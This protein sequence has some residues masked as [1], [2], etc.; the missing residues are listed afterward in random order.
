[1]RF[2]RQRGS[3]SVMVRVFIPN[4]LSTVGAGCTGLTYASTNLSIGWIRE[5]G[6]SFT[7]YT[8]ANIVSCSPGSWADPGSGKIGFC[9]VDATNYPGLYELQFHDGTAFGSQDLSQN[10]I[11]NILELTTAALNIGP[12]AVMIALVPW[13]YQDGAAMGLTNLD[14]TVSHGALSGVIEGTLTLQQV[15]MLLLAQA[16]GKS[17]GLGTGTV[18]ARNQAD[19]KNRIA[20][21]YDANGNITGVTL[22][23]T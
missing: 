17:T 5:L 3:T 7:A 20:A 13:N 6:A 4:S 11:I 16:A 14:T 18:N 22:D 9:P 12:N 21:T 23:L 19:S 2:P 8:G 15:M 1:M 10:V